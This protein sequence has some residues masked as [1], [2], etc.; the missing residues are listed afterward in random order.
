M[1]ALH[2]IYM[3]LTGKPARTRMGSH[4]EEVGFQGSDPSTDLRGVGVLALLNLS[5][6]IHHS[7]PNAKTLFE[8]SCDR[9]GQEFPLATLSI[10][11]T[12][13]ALQAL[14]FGLLHAYA[15]RKGSVVK[16][17][18]DY[19]VGVFYRFHEVWT[20]GGKTMNDSGWVI[21]ELREWALEGKNVANVLGR[22]SARLGAEQGLAQ[23][24]RIE[25]LKAGKEAKNEL[26]RLEFTSLD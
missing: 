22:L 15:E 13:I 24:R 6:L 21:K 3:R 23:S 20:L 19:Y 9:G 1:L 16:A 5:Y 2:T 8:L 4:W 18:N 7:F 11:V 26:A 10:N 14:R 12:G 17:L 25:A